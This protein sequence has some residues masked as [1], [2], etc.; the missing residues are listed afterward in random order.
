LVSTIC[1]LFL[2]LCLFMLHCLGPVF[3]S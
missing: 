2:F 3:R 1:F